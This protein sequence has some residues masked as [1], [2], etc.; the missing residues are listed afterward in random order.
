MEIWHPHPPREIISETPRTSEIIEGD[1]WSITDHITENTFLKDL[2]AR[3]ELPDAL[4]AL[5]SQQL[6]ITNCLQIAKHSGTAW[7]LKGF[8]YNNEAVRAKRPSDQFCP[9]SRA[10][11]SE[12]NLLY[13]LPFVL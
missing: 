2:Y 12:R 10:G 9:N 11:C 4:K 7:C 3:G 5:P 1:P 6:F 13:W 8:S